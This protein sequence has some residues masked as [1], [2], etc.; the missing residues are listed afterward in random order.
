MIVIEKNIPL[1]GFGDMI[2]TTLAQMEVTDSF[3]IDLA[4]DAS[5]KATLYRK[6]RQAAPREFSTRSVDGGTRVWRTA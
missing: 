4:G 5:L 6:M 2:S 3:L 1:P